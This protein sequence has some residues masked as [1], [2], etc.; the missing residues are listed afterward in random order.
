MSYIATFVRRGPRGS[1][2]PETPDKPSPSRPGGRRIG[3]ALA[4]SVVLAAM[5]LV[6]TNLASAQT[7]QPGPPSPRPFLVEDIYPGA[8]GSE[9]NHLMNLRGRLL[10]S[11]NHPDFGEE[12]W[13]SNGTAQTTE[14]VR[15]IDP[16]R[17]VINDVEVPNSSAPDKVMLTKRWIYFA[18]T[19]ASNG[20]ELWKSDGSN[21]GT[22]LVKDIVPGSGSSGAED[23]EPV[24]AKTTFFRAWDADHGEELWKTDGTQRGTTLV[25]DINPDAP[26]GARCPQ[27]QCGIPMGWSHPDTLTAMGK[28]V[29]FA[30]DDGVHGV[31]LWKS[32][33]TAGGTVMVKDINTIPGNS[34]PNDTTGADTRSAEV[35]KLFAVGDT[36]YFRANDGTNGLELWKTDGTAGGTTLVKDINPTTPPGPT[37]TACKRAKSCAGSSFVDDFTVV[38]GQIFLTANDGTN[39]VELWKT[40]GTAG[41]TTLVKDINPSSEIRASDT[42][43]LVAVG[44]TL[45]LSA[46]DGTNGLELWKSDGTAGGTVMVKDVN[47]GPADSGPDQLT[48]FDGRLLFTADDGQ[49]GIEVWG[50][51]GTEAGTRLLLDIEPGPAGSDPSE[52]IDAR[53]LLYF[54]ASNPSAGEALWAVRTRDVR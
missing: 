19:T 39:G 52:L 21:R 34:N 46:N 43:N 38:N 50:S 54:A 28:T 51:N 9:P 37:T 25:K 44:R 36:L 16:G 20:E 6:L 47:P 12:L 32:N 10:F 2:A 8:T 42:A 41:S 24:S 29:F 40:G 31:E 35:E 53:R 3:V 15:D 27:N 13:R 26:P 22:V 17:L 14:L 1:G 45:F 49:H 7:A 4:G 30:A 11:A 48:E 23:F 33:G 5:L 18:A